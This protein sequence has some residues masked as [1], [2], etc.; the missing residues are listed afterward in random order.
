LER[1]LKQ[2]DASYYNGSACHLDLVQW[3]TDP[4]WGDLPEIEKTKL[5]DSDLPFLAQQL[6]QENFRLLLLNGT[7]I[8]KAYEKHL[9][10]KLTESPFSDLGRLKLFTGSN[11]RGLKVVGWNI[12]LQTSYGVSNKEIDEIGA[13]V[14]AAERK[15]R[16]H[17]A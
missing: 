6:S 17:R 3:A 9:G 8:V 1:I 14:E 2:L 10:G 7:G 11:A 16:G 5:I 15:T 4:V 12:N 13:A